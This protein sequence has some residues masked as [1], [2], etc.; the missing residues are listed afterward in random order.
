MLLGAM[1]NQSFQSSG[2]HTGVVDTFAHEETGVVRAVNIVM[3]F[4]TLLSPSTPKLNIM[5][6]TLLC[7]VP[8]PW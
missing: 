6:Q 3:D 2:I 7:D 5:F 1:W 4:I 8:P